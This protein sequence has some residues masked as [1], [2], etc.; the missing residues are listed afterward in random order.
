MRYPA[1]LIYSNRIAAHPFSKGDVGL[2]EGVTGFH[3]IPFDGADKVPLVYG[4]AGMYGWAKNVSRYPPY[5][6]QIK[7]YL[8]PNSFLQI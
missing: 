3:E 8:S 6:F 2:C 7:K 4:K 5:L 1:E